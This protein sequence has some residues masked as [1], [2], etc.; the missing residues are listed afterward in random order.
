MLGLYAFFY[1]FLHLTAYVWFDK[2][3]DLRAVA[4]DVYRRPFIA[5]GMLSFFIMVPLA[6]TSTDRMI[7]RL[8]GK[9]WQKLHRLAYVAAVGGVF[10][11]WLLVK[12]DTRWPLT[13][14]FALALLL[15]YRFVKARLA[16]RPPT[17]TLLP[18]R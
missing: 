13:F 7:K 5:V 3:F 8:G 12:S 11:F 6:I 15:G 4:L 2:L 14:A 16:Y 10:H 18:P 9:R 17:R 1:G